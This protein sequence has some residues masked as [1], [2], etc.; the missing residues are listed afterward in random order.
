MEN[1]PY[2]SMTP[3]EQHEF[4]RLVHE[5]YEGGFMID[6]RVITNVEMHASL[7]YAERRRK[8]DQFV[9]DEL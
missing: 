4:G 1:K 5:R 2:H 3:Q 6:G 7:F 8:A 9:K